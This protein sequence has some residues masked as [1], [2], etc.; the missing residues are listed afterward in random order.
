MIH[1]GIVLFGIQNL[2]QSSC[3]VATLGNAELVYLVQAEEGVVEL[4]PL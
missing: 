2:E 4:D 3:R 1:V